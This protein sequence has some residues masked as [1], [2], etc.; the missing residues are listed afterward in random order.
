MPTSVPSKTIK[1]G[2]S[3]SEVAAWQQIL[4]AGPP[5]STWVDAAG[6][7]R[8]W[9]GSWPLATDGNFDEDTE[10]ATQAW[11]AA[12]GLVAD[13]V[14]GPKSWGAA[15]GTTEASK[16]HIASDIPYVPA[17]NYTVANRSTISLIVI[18]TME[19][20]EMGSTAENVAGFFKN[21]PKRGALD[22][23]WCRKDPKTGAL[24]PWEG[25]SAHYNIDVDSIV[26][27][28]VEKDIAWHAGPVNGRSVGLEH[29]GYAKQ[30][31]A[32]WAD[33]YS[34]A[35]LLRSAKFVAELC[36]RYDIPV[37]R[38]SAEELHAGAAGLCGHVDVTNALS[39]GNGHKDPGPNFP[40]DWYLEQIRHFL[41]PIAPVQNV[42][43]DE[44]WP[45]VEHAGARWAVAP[46]YLWPVTI[47]D[48][49]RYASEMGCELPTPELVDAIWQA[50]DLKLDAD[51][52]RRTNFVAW[53]QAEMSA[54]DVIEDQANKIQAQIAGRPYKLLGGMCK[55]VVRAESGVIGLY[56]WHRLD[57]RP[58]QPFFSGHAL[59]WGDYSQG[60]RLVRRLA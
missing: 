7:S 46:I 20:P 9:A 51:K 1:R 6:V 5:P 25:A 56:G 35:M 33:D 29:A 43:M 39:A 3:G 54:R 32:E 10:L 57:G 31:A 40:W 16:T 58:I 12:H 44:P 52:L 60:V 50:S 8:V 24:V 42:D 11:Q 41:S 27:S 19:A 28:V 17:K 14:V 18:H 34:M 26:C 15:G 55:D 2:S 45:V 47:G 4:N 30:T 22:P 59:S 48:A 23:V 53:S 21:Q 38:L 49:V 37:K 13:G 36:S